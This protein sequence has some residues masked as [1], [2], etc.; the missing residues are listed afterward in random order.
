MQIIKVES[1]Q[2]PLSH[3]VLI[4]EPWTRPT[5]QTRGESHGGDL[6][7]LSLVA[8]T[9]GM[10]LCFY[11]TYIWGRNAETDWVLTSASFDTALEVCL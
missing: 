4:T 3:C 11:T 2:L 5:Q 10:E 6:R 8:K 7:E 9:G 1:G